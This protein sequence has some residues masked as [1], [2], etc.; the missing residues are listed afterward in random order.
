[1]AQNEKIQAVFDEDLVATLR[2]TGQLKKIEDGKS[3]CNL[4]KSL[5]TL[6]NI[7][8]VV[9]FHT[10]EWLFVCNNPDCVEQYFSNK[11]GK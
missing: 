1:M 11:Q 2:K 10:S 7:Q 3:F 8:I 5:I 6:K 9:P 4:C